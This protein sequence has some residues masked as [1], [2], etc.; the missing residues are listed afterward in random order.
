MCVNVLLFKKLQ[1]PALNL[2]LFTC[3]HL[4]QRLILVPVLFFPAG[5]VGH[6]LSVNSQPFFW[7]A[8]EKIKCCSNTNIVWWLSLDEYSTA[9][10]KYEITRVERAKLLNKSIIYNASFTNLF[11]TFHQIEGEFV[12]D[13]L[14]TQRTRETKDYS[15]ISDPQLLSACNPTTYLELWNTSWPHRGGK[16]ECVSILWRICI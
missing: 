5:L 3:Q 11:M 10:S 15:V 12:P 9:S 8:T 2:S 13:I 7:E 14:F 1:I 4:K 16:R 6:F